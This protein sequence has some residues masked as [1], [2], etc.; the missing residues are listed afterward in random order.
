[1]DR[2]T[3][4]AASAGLYQLRRL[5]I[6]ANNLANANSVGFK[7][8]MLSGDTQRFEDTLASLESAK[9]PFA[10][11]DHQRTPGVVNIRAVTDFSPGAIKSTGNPLDVA[12]LDARDFFVVSTPEGQRYTRAGN[13][14]IDSAGQ[15]VTAD[16]FPVEGDG[17]P[18]TV[19]GSS[20]A[21]TPSG[22]VF[23]NGVNAGRL[24]VVRFENFDGLERGEASRFS[25]RAGS[26]QPAD[27]EAQVAPMALEMANVSAISSIIELI[28]SQRAFQ[29]YAKTAETSDMMNQTAINQI[30]RR[31]R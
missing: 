31:P 9:D 25:L 8:Q 28:S 4:S 14:S 23:V 15:L 21:I 10:L 16:G 5:E 17:G 7:R 11:P 27:V 3:Y 30:G 18:I 24:R 19:Q 2:G 20:P 12:L 6:V 13:F 1:M 29:M 26:S 22:G